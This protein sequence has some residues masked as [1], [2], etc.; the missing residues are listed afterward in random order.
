VGKV[1]SNSGRVIVVGQQMLNPK[2]Q[3]VKRLFRTGKELDCLYVNSCSILNKVDVLSA[4]V[5]VL[6]PNIIGIMESWMDETISDVDVFMEGYDFF[7]C[8]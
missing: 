3:N 2:A 5:R 4:N 7:R 1:P 8:D 6:D